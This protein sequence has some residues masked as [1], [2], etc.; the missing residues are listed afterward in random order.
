MPTGCQRGCVEPNRS[1]AL[2]LPDSPGNP[3]AWR[4]IAKPMQARHQRP[5]TVIAQAPAP[6]NASVI[7]GSVGPRV[8]SAVG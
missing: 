5:A 1:L 2:D 3:I 4:Q 7:N 8:A 6:R